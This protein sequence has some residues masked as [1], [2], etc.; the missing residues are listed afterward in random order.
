MGTDEGKETDSAMEID[1]HLPA[2][3]LW[4]TFDH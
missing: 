1:A 4:R 2:C 3:S